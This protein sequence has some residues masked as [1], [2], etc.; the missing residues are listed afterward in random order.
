M[1]CMFIRRALA[2][3]SLSS[4]LIIGASFMGARAQTNEPRVTPPAFTPQAYFTE[5]ALSPDRSEIVFVSG[6]DIWTVPAGGGLGWRP[7]PPAPRRRPLH[8]ELVGAVALRLV[9]EP[10]IRRWQA[11]FLHQF[12]LAG[13]YRRL[14]VRR[15]P[16]ARRASRTRL[17]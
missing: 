9:P 16:G 7:C 14:R 15:R 2:R 6:G 17:S 4:L 12:I 11:D 3:G 8:V 13:A 5:P 10:T 1:S